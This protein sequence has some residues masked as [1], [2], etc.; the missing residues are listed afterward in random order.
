ML[1]SDRNID[2]IDRN[3]LNNQKS[4]LRLATD[5]QNGQNRGKQSKKA[6]SKYKGVNSGYKGQ[7]IVQIK[8]P[9][10][11][12]STKSNFDSERDAA[13]AYDVLAQQHYGDFACLNISNASGADRERVKSL[14]S[15]WKFRGKTSKYRGVCLAK[16][17]GRWQVKFWM[18]GKC[19]YFGQYNSEL[20]AAKV[21]NREARLVFGEK[22]KLN[23]VPL[24]T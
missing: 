23:P 13:I 19:H 4:N 20:E 22:A 17:S 2:H 9:D 1:P 8:L 5:A 18:N 7:W 15:T 3:G 6:S 11:R 10:G 24:D 21:Y 12:F 14:L 16:D